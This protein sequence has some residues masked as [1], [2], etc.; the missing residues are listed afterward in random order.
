MS[1]SQMQ[2]IKGKYKILSGKLTTVYNKIRLLEQNQLGKYCAQ[3]KH[4]RISRPHYLIISFFSS[5]YGQ[6]TITA[7][8]KL[9]YK[10]E[11]SM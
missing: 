7:I 6:V 10:V 1:Y 5:L 4:Q 8:L 3:V 11:Y 9:F 2:I